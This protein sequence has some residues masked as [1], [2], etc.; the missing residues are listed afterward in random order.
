MNKQQLYTALS[1]TTKFEYLHVENIKDAYHYNPKNKH[2]VLSIGHSEYQN[3][4]IYRVDFD[5]AKIYIGST[6]KTLEKRLNEHLNDQKSIVHKHRDKNPKISLVSNCPCKNK[7][8]LEKIETRYI[9]KFAKEHPT[10]ILN[11]R[12]VEKDTPKLK[13]SFKIE[14]EDQLMARIEKMISIKR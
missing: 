2:E 11:K 3:G 5:D 14:K 4:K 12:G 10:K 13:Y 7:H 1:R 8:K 6:I 9:N